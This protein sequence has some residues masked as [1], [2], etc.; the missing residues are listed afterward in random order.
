MISHLQESTDTVQS[1]RR[2]SKVLLVLTYL[3]IWTLLLLLFWFMDPGDAFGYGLLTFWLVLPLTTLVLSFL[4]G[5][6]ESWGQ[7]RWAMLFFFGVMYLA[8]E[9]GTFTLANV[10]SA[11]Q[12]HVY[13]LPRWEAF[14][15]GPSAPPPALPWVLWFGSFCGGTDRR[16]SRKTLN[17]KAPRRTHPPTGASLVRSA[18]CSRFQWPRPSAGQFPSP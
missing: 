15:Q 6:D 5:K 16:L 10:L 13:P 12:P 17:A 4:I 14:S 7:W 18:E 11:R 8:M 9:Y 3:V 1:R 2:L